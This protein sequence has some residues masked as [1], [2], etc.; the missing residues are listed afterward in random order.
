FTN[1]HHLCIHRS[2]FSFRTLDYVNVLD[3]AVCDH[4]W[5]I[6]EPTCT[7]GPV[8][9][10]TIRLP[11]KT[12]LYSL[13]RTYCHVELLRPATCYELFVEI[14]SVANRE[15][16]LSDRFSVFTYPDTPSTPTNV[17]TF[18]VDYDNI[19]LQWNPPIEP[20]GQ[21][22]EYRVWYRAVPLDTSLY[23][24]RAST[25][26]LTEPVLHSPIV[27]TVRSESPS[28]LSSDGYAA[29]LSC[30]MCAHLCYLDSVSPNQALLDQATLNTAS[31]ASQLEMILFEDRLQNLLLFPRSSESTGY[32]ARVSRSDVAN[33]RRL[34][35]PVYGI[36]HRGND[37]VHF[38]LIPVALNESRS[39]SVT[40]RGLRHYTSYRFGISVCHTPHDMSG[41]PLSSEAAQDLLQTTT[42]VPWCSR[43]AL[44]TGTTAASLEKDRL[45]MAAT[46]VTTVPINCTSIDLSRSQQIIC[47]LN[48]SLIRNA[49]LGSL[50]NN[51]RQPKLTVTSIR[52]SAP[53][54][55]NGAILHYWFRYRFVENNFA[56]DVVKVVTQTV[57][58]ICVK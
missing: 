19:N 46:S 24:D 15:G 58:I 7:F 53:L 23:S 35:G 34:D 28:N 8:P 40:I 2:S 12:S 13:P 51:P 54:D 14:R 57:V 20:N 39:P 37:E 30:T 31:E 49:S 1:C 32:H 36:P 25:T 18:S 22:I 44:I 56:K 17:R 52:W 27:S 29:V 11:N 50:I 45:D 5:F 42:L 41:R 47:K 6:R 16:A 9:E 21:S 26:C 55:P 33:G 3:E 10:D 43:Y 48:D 4:K 38:V